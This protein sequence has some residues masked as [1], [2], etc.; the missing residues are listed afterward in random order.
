ML[1]SWCV[2]LTLLCIPHNLFK[3]W[4][5][6]TFI[7]S[8]CEYLV[9]GLL[10]LKGF[11]FCCSSESQ[12]GCFCLYGNVP[13]GLSLC[14]YHFACAVI[15]GAFDDLIVLMKYLE[16]IH[17]DHYLSFVWFDLS[18][19]RQCLE[20]SCIGFSGTSIWDIRSMCT[21]LWHDTIVPGGRVDP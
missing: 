11:I 20:N 12:E 15:G 7:C 14:W 9:A 2:L 3:P 8:S 10:C 1:E 6:F 17:I 4:I 19:G 21:V 16:K 13:A 18:A 5:W